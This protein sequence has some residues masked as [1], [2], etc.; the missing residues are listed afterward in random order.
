VRDGG[1]NAPVAVAEIHRIELRLPL[2]YP[3]GAPAI[4]WVTRIFHPNISNS[5]FVNFRAIGLAWDSDLGLDVVV[6][7]LWDVARAAYRNDEMASNFSA[8]SWYREQTAFE[9][10]VDTRILRDL[11]PRSNIIRY[12]RR[13]IMRV[14]APTRKPRGDVLYIDEHTP[15]PDLPGRVSP[16]RDITD[17]ND[18]LYIG[19]E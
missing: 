17:G 2:S 9:L 1:A 6:E 12:E 14:A 4:R 8:R 18:V 13:G 7:R 11:S 19:D 16:P 15:T 3:D 10:P 5:G